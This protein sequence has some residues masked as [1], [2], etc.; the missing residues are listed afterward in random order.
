M[1]I[2]QPPA[3]SSRH[4]DRERKRAARAYVVP[5]LRKLESDGIP[6][7]AANVDAMAVAARRRGAMEACRAGGASDWAAHATSRL[8]PLPIPSPR[9]AQACAREQ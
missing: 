9:P 6:S 7:N 3:K 1:D 5:E 2:Q 8:E 4:L